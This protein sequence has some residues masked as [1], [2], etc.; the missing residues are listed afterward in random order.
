LVRI[1]AARFDSRLAFCGVGGL[2]PTVRASVALRADCVCFVAGSRR[3]AD[4]IVKDAATVLK[5][6]A[7]RDPKDSTSAD[8]PVPNY[9]DR[10]RQAGEGNEDRSAR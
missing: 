2:M 8:M 10:D 5:V 7:G 3:T 1:P 4:E 6:I 9:L